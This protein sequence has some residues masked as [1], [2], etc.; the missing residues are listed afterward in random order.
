MIIVPKDQATPS[1]LQE[2]KVLKDGRKG[3]I[4]TLIPQ[5]KRTKMVLLGFP[6]GYG[7]EVIT[8]LPQVVEASC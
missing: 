2:T 3:S 4:S 7:V 8:S 5:E 6:L 1:F